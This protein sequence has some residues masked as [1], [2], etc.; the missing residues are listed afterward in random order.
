MRS[1]WR[2]AA[3]PPALVAAA[4]MA[5]APA[6]A[7]AP[8]VLT[9]GNPASDH[10][11]IIFSSEKQSDQALTIRTVR[12]GVAG[13]RL[14]LSIDHSPHPLFSK[15]LSDEECRFGDAGSMCEFTISGDTTLYMNIVHA[16]RLGLVA[17]L[18]VEDSG[19]MAMAESVSL[20]GFTAAHSRL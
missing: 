7:S 17:H 16:F 8:L 3:L 14:Q 12:V 2:L 9:V 5:V 13:S 4:F 15:I 20:R 1:Y 11:Q 6:R 18:T 19:V 10:A